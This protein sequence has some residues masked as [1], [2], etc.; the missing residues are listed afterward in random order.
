MH[1]TPPPPQDNSAHRADWDAIAAVRA[2]V[3]IPV[4]ANG[5]V[6]T[7]AD[8]RALMQHTGADGVLSAEP[9]LM[10]PALYSP[11]KNPEVGCCDWFYSV[12]T[13]FTA[14]RF[15]FCCRTAAAKER[16]FLSCCCWACHLSQFNWQAN[17]N[18]AGDESTGI[19]P[20]HNSVNLCRSTKIFCCFLSVHHRLFRALLR[21]LSC[22]KSIY[23][24]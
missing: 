23:H 22:V 11:Q 16:C 4:L 15:Q 14:A 19:T 1:L 17:D 2:A 24:W 13:L 8:A 18:T 5:D 21:H 20:I 12:I 10:D 9:L 6:R 3:Q 7:F